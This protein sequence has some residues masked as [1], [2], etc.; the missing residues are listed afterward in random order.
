VLPLVVRIYFLLLSLP[1][2]KFELILQFSFS[3]AVELVPLHAAVKTGK[4]SD[5]LIL[6]LC[7]KNGSIQFLAWLL[8][9]AIPFLVAVAA[10]AS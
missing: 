6:L 10:A 8:G 3:P 2:Y 1:R 4:K 5:L 9:A 7:C